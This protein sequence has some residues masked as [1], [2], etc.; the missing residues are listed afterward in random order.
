M[1]SLKRPARDVDRWLRAARRYLRF[2][3]RSRAQVRDYLI[4]RKAPEPVVA[5]VLAACAREG[6]IDDRVA[7]KLWAETLRQRGYAL[8]AIHLQLQE[9]GFDDS[10]IEQAL[11]ALRV[12]EDDEQ[13]ARMVVAQILTKTSSGS[14]R[15]R[16]AS[17]A[18][19]L[20]RRGFD[21][22]LIDRLLSERKSNHDE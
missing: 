14:A 15:G 6:L 1:S 3:T 13:R 10:T 8:S 4:D 17:V 18:R 11:N 2:G 19:R 12:R 21:P 7:A 20:A 22:E 9:R 16:R 5:D